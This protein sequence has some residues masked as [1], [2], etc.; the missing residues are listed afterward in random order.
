[1]N[2]ASGSCFDARRPWH[3]DAGMRKLLV[4]AVTVAASA[5]SAGT[6]GAA[7]RYHDF[8]A[9]VDNQWFPLVL[10]TRYLYIGVKDRRPSRDVV[11]VTHQT[12]TIAGAPCVVVQDRLYLDGRLAE[13]TTDW[14]SQDARGNVWYFG[15]NT[16]ELDAHGHVTNTE[17]TWTAGVKGA[18]SHGSGAGQRGRNGEQLDANRP[19]LRAS[20]TAPI[21]CYGEPLRA[22]RA[23]APAGLDCDLSAR[24]ARARR[25]GRVRAG[26]A[27]TSSSGRRA[28]RGRGRGVSG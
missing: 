10:G 5:A 9:H 21:C 2:A 11:T 20:A 7:S 18:T 25:G 27:S 24:R 15:E 19:P 12:K 8:T 28:R 4:V 23:Q 16:A 3:H 17:G 1:M 13:R 22:P 26:R 14:Y 6:T